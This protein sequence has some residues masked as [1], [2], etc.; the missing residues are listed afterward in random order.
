MKL[1]TKK[2]K[3]TAISFV[4]L[5]TISAMIVAFSPTANAAVTTYYSYVYCSVGNSVIGINQPQ[6]LIWWTADMPPD[7]GE[8]SG[9]A[10]VGEQLGM[11]LDFTL[12]TLKE[13][14]KP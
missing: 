7:I 8:I 14:Q 3:A 13:T 2:A 4:T 12:Q 5:L 10:P 11:M 1:S 9:T 6:L